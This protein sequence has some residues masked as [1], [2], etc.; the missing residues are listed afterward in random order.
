MLDEKFNIIAGHSQSMLHSED[1]KGRVNFLSE[2]FS[3]NLILALPT[4]WV[5]WRFL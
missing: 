3:N 5:A 1:W 4:P 2:L